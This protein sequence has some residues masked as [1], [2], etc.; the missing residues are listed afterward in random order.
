MNNSASLKAQDSSFDYA[1]ASD[2]SIHKFSPSSSGFAPYFTPASPF[3]TLGA[4][5]ITV[6]SDRIFINSTESTN[7]SYLYGS[8]SSNVSVFAY[9][10]EASGPSHV[11]N[12]TTEEFLLPP[13]I[14]TSPQITKVFIVGNGNSSNGSYGSV[15]FGFHIDWTLKAAESIGFPTE[16]LE[17]GRDHFLTA[18]EDFFLIKQVK[19]NQTYSW[20]PY[21][22]QYSYSSSID[23]L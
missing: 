14:E 18:G 10:I 19:Y 23:L 7:S 20:Q 3:P 1:I 12:F 21:H 9:L 15:G 5:S 16:A 8:N 17:F 22:I 2:G 13:E 6:Y 4:V 11:F